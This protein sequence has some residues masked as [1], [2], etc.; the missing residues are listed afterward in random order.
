MF[1]ALTIAPF[2]LWA[3]SAVGACAPMTLTGD[4]SGRVVNHHDAGLGGPGDRRVMI[5]DVQ[6]AGETIG[7]WRTVVEVLDPGES[8]R[9]MG[10][11]VWELDDGEIHMIEISNLIR[12]FGDT[13]QP[14]INKTEGAITGG[15]GAY[16]HAT[17][18]VVITFDGVAATF[19]FDIKCD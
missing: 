14:S 7:K 8:P 3:N 16:A 9:A 1:R 18:T 10:T 6:R 2:V 5:R 19:E 15:T 12:S 13:S 17:G 11:N 4:G